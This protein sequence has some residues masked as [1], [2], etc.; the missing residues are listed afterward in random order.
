MGNLG[1]SVPRTARRGETIESC[2]EPG[3]RRSTPEDAWSCDP[4]SPNRDPTGANTERLPCQT[5]PPEID[6]MSPDKPDN[7]VR[8]NGKS[9]CLAV[10]R[11]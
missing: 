5:P 9:L 7:S 8:D 1:T 6:M 10:E 3:S 11:T 4:S 2:V